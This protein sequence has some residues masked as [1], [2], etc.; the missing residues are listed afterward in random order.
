MIYTGN[1]KYPIYLGNTE[2][3]AIYLG[4]Y[5]IYPDV[6]ELSQL[7]LSFPATGGSQV[8]TITSSYNW[9]VLGSYWLTF[10]Q[11]D[12]TSGTTNITVTAEPNNTGDRN[13]MVAVTIVGGSRM[14]QRQF[15]LDVAQP[16]LSLPSNTFVF[17]F[18][19]KKYNS[20][21][22]T[23]PNTSGASMNKNMVMSAMTS[24]VRNQ[25]TLDTDHLVVPTS[26]FSHFD[27][28]TSG[29]N[30]INNTTSA[31]AMT[32]I[33]KFKWKSGGSN[34][35]CNRDN[36]TYNFMVRTGAAGKLSLHT[37]NSNSSGTNA[38]SY[39][40]GSTVTALWRVNTSRQVDIKN[41]TTNVS[42]TPFTTTWKD[43]AT[44]FD[45]FIWKTTGTSA[46]FTEP[47]ALDFYWCYFSKE[48]L[49]DAEVQQVIDFNEYM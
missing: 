9:T 12:G 43:G 39:S 48:A 36:S 46:G 41:I 20:S 16:K 11:D 28:S 21:T 8:I 29:A 31:P 34:F 25:I 17:N 33:A 40:T 7:S 10:S 14:G 5:Q 45:F 42:N 30:P 38:V 44:Y 15:F 27:F 26:A 3:P 2:I 1:N 24:T 18:N 13:G 23:I 49:T 37:A 47:M 22:Y 4:N 35:I 32:V 19:A 6:F